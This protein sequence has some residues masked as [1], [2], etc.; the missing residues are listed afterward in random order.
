V[1][2]MMPVVY[3]GRALP[4]AWRVRKGQTGHWP[5]AWHITLVEQGQARRPAGAQGVLLGDG[6]SDGTALH[7]TLAE[8]EWPDVCRTAL[9][10]PATW[11][12]TTFR[13]ATRGQV[14]SRGPGWRYTRCA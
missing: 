4:L 5:E 11:E 7:H 8:A 1:A 14:A 12:D 3:K 2:L 13:L 6:E 9:S 10:T